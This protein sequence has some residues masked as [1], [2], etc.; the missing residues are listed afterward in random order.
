MISPGGTVLRLG[1]AFFRGEAPGSQLSP[2]ISRGK[3]S[4]LLGI[5]LRGTAESTPQSAPKSAHRRL[6][7]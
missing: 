6:L 4:L 2:S 7:L 1:S 5:D 3:I